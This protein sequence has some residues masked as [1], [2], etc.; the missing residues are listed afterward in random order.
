MQLSFSASAHASTEAPAPAGESF[1]AVIAIG[2]VVVSI[3]IA[4]S[5][6]RIRAA[7]REAGHAKELAEHREYE[8]NVAQQELL[9]RL[10]EERELVKEK[11]QIESRLS[12]YEKYASLAQQ[13]RPLLSEFQPPPAPVVISASK[14][15]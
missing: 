10:E 6:S 2:F 7:Q 14:S 9:R 8:R 3:V 5:G 11:M 4:V 12:E 1:W 15:S 13:F